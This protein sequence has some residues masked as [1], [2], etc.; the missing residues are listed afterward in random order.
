[1]PKILNEATSLISSFIRFPQFRYMTAVLFLALPFNPSY[2]QD[3][4]TPREILLDLVPDAV[5]SL[6]P[7]EDVDLVF[8]SHVSGTLRVVSF[9]E[10]NPQ[11]CF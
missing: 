8:E 9:K 5:G 1:M 4:D 2:S 6:L 7:S 10:R 11:D 3:I